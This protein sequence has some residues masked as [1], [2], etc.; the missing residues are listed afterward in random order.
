MMLPLGPDDENANNTVD[1][2]FFFWG[3]V[4]FPFI[5]VCSGVRLAGGQGAGGGRGGEGWGVVSMPGPS[6]HS[7]VSRC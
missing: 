7:N 6:C 5:F 2:S 3:G 4:P 1:G